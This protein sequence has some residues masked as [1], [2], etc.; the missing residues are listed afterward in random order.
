MSG[1]P[2]GWAYAAFGDVVEIKL[3]KMLDK[4]KN[5]GDLTPYLR[6]INVRWGHFSLTDV[7]EMRV[8]AE[9]RSAFSIR[10][11]DLLVC[12]GGEPGRN[13]I[14]NYGRT[15]LTFQKA[16]MRIRPHGKISPYLLSAYLRKSYVAGQLEP[17]FTG[18]TIRHLPQAALSE[19]RI[20]LPP[21][22]EQ[23]RIVAKIDSLSAKSKR[24]RDHLDH[25]PRLVEKYKQAVLA[26]AFRGDLTREWRHKF[27]AESPTVA[28]LEWQRENAKNA[29]SR[30]SPAESYDWRP[31]ISLPAGWM[32][33]SVDQLAHIIQYGSSAKTGDDEAG[34][35]VFRMGNIQGG[36][37]TLN[38]LKYLPQEHGEFPDLL[39]HPGDLLFNRTNS[40]E[41][42]GK[43]AVYHGKPEAASFA[44][45]LIRVR[46]SYFSPELL[47]AYINSAI[48]REWV[49][50][51]VNQQVGQANVN[52]SKLRRL[53]VPVMSKDEQA[54]IQIRINAAFAWID[55]LAADATSA[56]KLIDGLDQAILAKAFRGELV[57]QDSNDE[58]ASLLLERIKA[59]R[60]ATPTR[61]RGR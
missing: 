54:E 59:E 16:L 21:L 12:E 22:P 18:T 38:S 4:S 41:L 31:D 8:T 6:N 46:L 11:G 53:G 34:V 57:P 35:P 26:A 60:G 51:A 55:R 3:G 49:A 1:L 19:I 48:G 28:D 27:S 5:R 2:K 14:W 17:S 7:S 15:K 44:S 32:W 36:A 45:Y 56:R 43:T 61:R 10:D 9:E 13:A 30:R 58:P 23:R 24:A 40:A 50:G 25:I 37:L 39:L 42:V 52:G 33:A 20:P 29:N 47:S